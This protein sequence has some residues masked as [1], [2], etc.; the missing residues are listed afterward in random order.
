MSLFTV[1]C[2]GITTRARGAKPFC[3]RYGLVRVTTE[4]A[5]TGPTHRTVTPVIFNLRSTYRQLTPLLGITNQ[6]TRS[7][8]RSRSYL[9]ISQE[10]SDFPNQPSLTRSIFF[11]IDDR[12]KEA[13]SD[14]QEAS[15]EV[16]SV[17]Q[18]PIRSRN[19]LP[20][21]SGKITQRKK[22]NS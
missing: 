20:H 12:R 13:R 10:T 3:H 4:T 9:W 5:V 17:C 7:V 22:K 8:I 6:S 16:Q 18:T 11:K 19:H 21:K 1:Y 2:F 14:H 15:C